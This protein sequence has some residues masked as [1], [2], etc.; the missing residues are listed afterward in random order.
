MFGPKAS[1]DAAYNVDTHKAARRASDAIDTYRKTGAEQ[2]KQKSESA[3][4]QK[5]EIADHLSQTWAEANKTALEHPEYGEFFKPREGDAEWNQR[6][7]KGREL[8]QRGFAEDPFA[9][10]L[11]PE[12][13][14]AIVQRHAAILNRAAAFGA[15]RHRI[16]TLES[17][18]KERDEA[19]A[20]YEES[21]PKPGEANGRQTTNGSVGNAKDRA[22][23]ALDS[24][25]YNR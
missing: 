21:E 13:R 15:M 5:K 19:L 16:Q 10:N 9:E 12:Q 14:K 24:G 11:T 7:A 8:A 23:A 17:Q 4:R 3:Q 20:A 25:K 1:S 22:M 6:L 18:I 2:E